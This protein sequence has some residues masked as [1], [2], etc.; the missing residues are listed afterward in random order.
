MTNANYGASFDALLESFATD[1]TEAPKKSWNSPLQ[2]YSAI[3]SVR[4]SLHRPE[5]CPSGSSDAPEAV[6]EILPEFVP[7]LKGLAPGQK[8]TVLTW[9]HLANRNTLQ[10][11]ECGVFATH[12]S[13]R[14]N[15]IG[16]HEA[17][18]VAME[19]YA[20]SMLLRLDALEVVDGTP[21][22]DIKGDFSGT[23]GVAEALTFAAN[24]LTGICAVAHNAGLLVGFN[25]N[26]SLRLGNFCV[27][28]KSRS[29]KAGLTGSDFVALNLEDGQVLAGPGPSIETGMHLGIYRAQPAAKAVLHTHPTS[30]IALALRMPGQSMAE[31]LDMPIFEAD[32]LR[33]N[34]GSVPRLEPGSRELAEA[35][36]E[37]AKEHQAIWMDGHG[38]CVW[39]DTATNALA[40]S[41]Q[42]EGLARLRLHC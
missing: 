38:L 42:L 36:A 20:S 37:A 12:G 21:V 19:Y 29:F 25:G 11:A 14:P 28:T 1:E 39:A 16:L 23:E 26:A 24:E 8:I 30:L 7:G 9:L 10:Q 41:E 2:G 35:V 6:L 17:T 13:G 3:G 34:I 40:L 5:E 15:P 18:I 32:V 33:R 31:R 22:L 4:S 27:I